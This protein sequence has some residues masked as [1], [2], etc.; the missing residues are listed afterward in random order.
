MSAASW[1][2]RPEH[3]LD[4]NGSCRRQTDDDERGAA[5]TVEEGFVEG[6]LVH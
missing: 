3:G 5:D 4:R 1:P 2:L 6:N